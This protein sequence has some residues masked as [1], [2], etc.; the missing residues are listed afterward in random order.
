MQVFLSY[1]SVDNTADSNGYLK[2]LKTFG[3]W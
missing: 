1:I 2:R 3:E